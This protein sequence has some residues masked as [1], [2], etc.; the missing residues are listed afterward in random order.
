MSLREVWSGGQV[1]SDIAGLRAARA[2]GL[3]TAGWAPAGWKT[4]HGPS[5]WLA[6][7]GLCEA[8]GGYAHRTDRNV[9]DTDGTVRLAFDFSTGGELCTIKAIRRH[10]KPH[11]DVDLAKPCSPVLVAD[12]IWEN[13]IEVLNV[14]GNGRTD[15]EKQVE[16]YLK[17]VFKNVLEED[18]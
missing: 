5:P 12:W 6:D 4:R 9:A 11:F 1:G 7:Y 16:E 17:I 8:E 3:K 14:A 13:D 15:I 18:E 10:N 2:C